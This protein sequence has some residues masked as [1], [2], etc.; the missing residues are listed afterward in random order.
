MTSE[1][2]PYRPNIKLYILVGLLIVVTT[3]F[4]ASTGPSPTT[5]S[6]G[7]VTRLGGVC[8]QLERWGLFGWDIIGQSYSEADVEDGRWH[9]PPTTNP[10]CEIVEEQEFV[11]LL[12][13]DAP[14]DS[15]RVCG[16]A[17][18][19]GCLEVQLVSS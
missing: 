12:P 1:P 18:D 17:D 13:E 5:E 2:G 7:S 15:Y 19:R 11:V 9:L 6:T 4:L 14:L 16:L 8:L 3:I 10:P